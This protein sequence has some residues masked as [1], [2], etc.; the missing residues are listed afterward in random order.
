[1]LAERRLRPGRALADQ[2]QF[3]AGHPAAGGGDHPVGQRHHLRGGAV[4]ALQAHH[5]GVGEPPGEVQQELRRGP[6]EGVDGLVGVADDGEVIT[7]AEP[8]V[9]HPLLQWGDV[10]V[11]VDDEAA[12][13]VAELTGHRGVVLDGGG[14]VQQQVV[15]VQQGDAVAVGFQLFV[16]GVDGGDLGGVQGDVAGHLGDGGGVALGADERGLGPLDFP[17]EVADVVGGHLQLGPVG[18]LGHHGELAVQ[19]LPA[20]GADHPRPEV[21]QLAPC[22]GMEGQSLNA[23]DVHGPQPAAHLPRGARG[24]GHRQ[25][26][27]GG[28]VALGHQV[29]DPV[30]DGAGL[31][32]AR[33]GQDTHRSPGGQHGVALLLV[34]AGGVGGHGVHLG[35]RE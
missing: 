15:E 13:A 33:P 5:G 11:L 12:V 34:E 10:L 30:G 22:C 27:R 16:A 23:G 18:G 2:V 25:H 3:G 24:E 26:L 4:V 6:G 20:G 29:P 19:Q 35:S 17:G 14:G 9:E 31:A 28:D 32:G 1:M 21:L 8:G 7:V